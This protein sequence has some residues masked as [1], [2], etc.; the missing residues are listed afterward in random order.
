MYGGG[1]APPVKPSELGSFLLI[2]AA[3]KN[4]GNIQPEW[5]SIGGRGAH[6]SKDLDKVQIRISHLNRRPH[7]SGY[8]ICEELLCI[9]AHTVKEAFCVSP[10]QA[11]LALLHQCER[12]HGFVHA[13]QLIL[14]HRPKQ[15]DSPHNRHILSLGS[16]L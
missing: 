11:A 15:P 1:V 6:R 16:S 9:L 7:S 3:A 12:G 10:G 4:C 8:S 14:N 5:Q 13:E 2:M